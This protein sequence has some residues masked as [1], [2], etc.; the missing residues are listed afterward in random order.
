[1]L[2]AR[3]VTLLSLQPASTDKERSWL[4]KQIHSQAAAVAVAVRLIQSMARPVLLL[5]VVMT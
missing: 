2:R 5:S 1:M 3:A 4:L